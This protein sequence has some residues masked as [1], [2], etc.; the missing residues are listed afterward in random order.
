MGDLTQSKA[1]LQKTT[2]KCCPLCG[3]SLLDM[4]TESVTHCPACGFEL[5]LLVSPQ[6]S[7]VPSTQPIYISRLAYLLLG[8][9]IIFSAVFA[10][11]FFIFASSF[12]YGVPQL[13]A[14]IQSLT[15]VILVLFAFILRQQ[16]SLVVIRVGLVI[17]GII[18]LPPGIFAIA[19]ALAISP[20]RRWCVVCGK[21]IR[22][23]AYI[24][25]NHCK[26]SMHRWGSC[27]TKRLE[28]ITAF[29][30]PGI[31]PIQLEWTCPNC[32]ELMDPQYKGGS[33]NE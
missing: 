27:R 21:Q 16:K 30:E 28:T 14:T 31:S 3:E 15:I 26:T 22:W 8:A 5:S 32:H 7:E 17:V 13:I 33:M 2:L 6:K 25:C 12:Y 18:S 4:P 29:S 24:E 19:T 20:S 11:A 10:V 23:G 9:Q 1:D